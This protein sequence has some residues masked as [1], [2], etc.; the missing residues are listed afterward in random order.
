VLVVELRDGH[1]DVL[2][3][4]V[5]AL[6]HRFASNREFQPLEFAIGGDGHG[7]CFEVAAYIPPRHELG[8][9]AVGI[10]GKRAGGR[11]AMISEGDPSRSGVDRLEETLSSKNA[12]GNHIIS[13]R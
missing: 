7:P 1:L 9:P 12:D 3:V 8:Q 13:L 10:E 2:L 5:G 11:P 6:P 4:T